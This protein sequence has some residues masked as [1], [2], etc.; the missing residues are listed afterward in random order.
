MGFSLFPKK[1]LDVEGIWG[2][3]EDE[4]FSF[5]PKKNLDVEGI[6]GTL[7]DAHLTP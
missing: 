1:N 7:G 4:F 2:T 3:L 6:W 5:F